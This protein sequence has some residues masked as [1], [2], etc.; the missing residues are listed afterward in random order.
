V[1]LEGVVYGYSR[2]PR[3]CQAT[4][5]HHLGNDQN[6]IE[7]VQKQSPSRGRLWGMK[8]LVVV[9]SQLEADR[10]PALPDSRLVVSGVGAVSAALATQAALLETPT[11]LVLS[12]G[13]AGAYPNS[14]LDLGDVLVSSGVV[15]AGLGVQNGLRVDALGFTGAEQ[16]LPVWDRAGE[17]AQ[18]AKLP[19]GIIAT[20]ETVTTDL[21]R[22][23]AIESQFRAVAEAMEGAGVAQAALRHGL[24]M[25]EVRAVSNMVGDR[26]N[27]QIKTALERLGVA[28][29]GGWSFL[30]D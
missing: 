16:V 22:A 18:A 10:L 11:D 21:A 17:F 13:I 6:L 9:A 8:I 29:E 5:Q 15:Y 24:P 14:G 27:W 20:L 7:F 12:V 28:L 3:T 23:E 26:Q 19:L 30:C 25:L 1:T 4:L 2:M